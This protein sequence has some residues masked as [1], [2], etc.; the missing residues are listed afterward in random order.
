MPY[1]IKIKTPQGEETVLSRK[2][3][4]T[5]LA[6]GADTFLVEALSAAN[7][8]VKAYVEAGRTILNGSVPVSAEAHG[9][10][11]SVE[12]VGGNDSDE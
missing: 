6:T 7:G 5:S 8:K 4:K 9:L 12:Q 11:V 10:A 2:R 3:L 1:E